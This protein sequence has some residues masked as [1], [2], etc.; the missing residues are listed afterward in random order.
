MNNLL[1]AKLQRDILD[2]LSTFHP[3]HMTASQYFDCFGD[4]DEF[5]MLANV[6]ALINQGLINENAIHICDGE[7]FIS[8]GHLKLSEIALK[9]A[10]P[11]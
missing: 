4:C 3:H 7:K 5:R 9:Q 10:S 1:S 2:A 6:E 8:L 11:A